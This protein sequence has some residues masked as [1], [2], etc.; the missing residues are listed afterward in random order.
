MRQGLNR[1]LVSLPSA[2]LGFAILCVTSPA[3]GAQTMVA[4]DP[5]NGELPV[6]VAVDWLG[7]KYVSLQPICEVRRYDAHW[8]PTHTF[9]L[10]CD[11]T[12]GD[13]GSG[14]GDM[15]SGLVVQPWGTFYAAVANKT[16]Q[17]NQGVYEVQPWGAMRRLPGTE[18]MRFPNS[19]AF[20][21]LFGTLYVTDF[22]L[23]QIWRIRPHHT[24]EVWSDAPELKSMI[25]MPANGLSVRDGYAIVSISMPV[26]PGSGLAAP[27]LVRIPIERDGS[28]GKVETLVLSSAFGKLP[29]P[30]FAFVDD[31][32]LDAVGNIYVSG[33]FPWSVLR[34]SPDGKEIV[35]VAD[36]PADGLPSP[37]VSLAFDNCWE[38]GAQL[39]VAI[40]PGVGAG[41]TG[42]AILRID[43]GWPGQP[44]SN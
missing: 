23:G 31:I 28:A 24:A 21:H 6:S 2:C 18:K 1:R 11:K 13:M 35:K 39:L 27:Q 32:T 44:F 17:G 7:N 37:V 10:P 15:G 22:G 19:L 30:G 8:R 9:T 36:G 42:S 5:S 33:V 4:Y 3:F 41:G 26:P 40:N 14:N 43:L 16:G 25:G 12:N 38:H 34:V 29:G 20:D